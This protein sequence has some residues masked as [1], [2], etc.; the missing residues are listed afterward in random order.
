[1]SKVIGIPGYKQQDSNGFGVGNHY[2]SLA[3]RYGN[4]RIIMPWEEH[5]DVDLLILP[6]G[7]DIN[8]TSYG[9]IP[10]FN[11]GNQDVFKQFFFDQRLANYVAKG[12]PIFGI[13]LGFQQL[14]AF[15]G[16]KITQHM[17]YHKQSA[18][19]MT[20]GHE[21]RVTDY[22]PLLNLSFKLTIKDESFDVNSHHHQ[23]VLLKDLSPELLPLLVAANEEYG[24][25]T[26]LR[27]ETKI[28]HNIVESFIH[29]NLPIGGCQ[30]HPEEWHDWAS[31]ALI[32]ELLNRK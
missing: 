28:E 16:S 8:P 1:M 22:I 14:A 19:R 7:M 26:L 18:G 29:H 3:S 21:V 27:T 4:P 20:K 30:Y 10:Q 12:T 11:T 15:F 5:V 2:L 13:C 31:D 17:A 23:G 25:V 24:D 6:G 9:E 32:T